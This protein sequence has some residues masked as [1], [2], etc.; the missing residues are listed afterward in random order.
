MR[1]TWTVSLHVPHVT[2]ANL[3]SIIHWKRGS[4]PKLVALCDLI[5]FSVH[6]TAL[7]AKKFKP[8]VRT[9]LP[10]R[11]LI[12]MWLATS[13]NNL[14][15]YSSSE[16]SPYIKHVL[17]QEIPPRKRSKLQFQSTLAPVQMY[18]K[19]PFCTELELTRAEP[20]HLVL[21]TR[22]CKNM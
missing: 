20:R 21:Q 6:W 12:L 1:K 9:E 16:E 3:M 11:A 18:F 5:A 19:N 22:N 10:A 13:T 2:S 8:A 4:Q 15:N 17:E 7:Q 14:Q